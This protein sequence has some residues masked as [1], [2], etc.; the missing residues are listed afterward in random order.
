M[1]YLQR[2]LIYW[3]VAVGGGVLIYQIHAIPWPVQFAL[4]MVYCI[5]LAVLMRVGSRP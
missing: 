2:N 5:G 1:T 4:S 3:P